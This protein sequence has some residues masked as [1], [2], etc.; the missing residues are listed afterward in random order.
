MKYDHK[1]IEKKWQE[2]WDVAQSFKASD[3]PRPDKKFYILD[4]FPYPSGD[5]LHVGHVEGYT[6]TDI[7]SRFKRMQSYDVLHPMGWDA[8]GLPAENYAIK[9]GVPP[10]QTTDKAID[11]FRRQIKELGLSY[12][13]SREVGAHTPEYYKW[14]QWFFLFLYNNGLAYKRMAKVNWCPKDQTVLANEQ[15]VSESG[16]KG[17]CVR[18]GTKVIQ[19]DL[20]QWFFKITDFAD[21]LVDDLDQVDWPESTKINQRNW[22]G[23][24]EGAEIEFAIAGSD[25][26]IKVFTTRP[27]TLFGATYMVLAPEHQ[28]VQDLKDRIENWSKIET[29]IEETKNKTDI[30]RASEGRE[31]TGVELKGVKAINPANKEEVSVYIA[32]YVM[33][34]YG[35]GAIMAVPAHD[36]RDAEFAAKFNIPVRRVVEPVTMQTVGSSAFKQNDPFVDSHGVI[37]FLKHWAEDK[38]MGLKWRDASD[39]GTLLTGGIDEGMTG[40]DTTRKEILEETGYKNIKSLRQ[41]TTIHSKYYHVPKKLNRFGHAP[42]FVVELADGERDTVSDEEQTKH[43]RLWLSV[44]ELKT[45]LTAESHQL[46]LSILQGNQYTGAGIL[47]D[48]GKFTGMQSEEAK[49]KITKSVDGSMVKTYRLRDW[50]ISR[51]R[52]WGAPI[53]VVYDPEGKAHPI[54]EEHLPWV[55]PTDVEFRPTGT[56][57]LGQSKELLDRTEKIFGKGWRPEIDT[58]DTFVCSS[59]YYFR[60][61]DPHNAQEFASKDALQ[62]WLPVDLYMGGAEHTVL[63]LLYARF[64][65][66]A[67]QKHGYV[68]FG[69]PFKKLRHQGIILA[70]DSTKMSKSKG[71]VIN[72]D[73]VIREYGADALRMYEMFMGPIEAMKPWSTKNIT[74][75]ARFLERVYR[76]QRADDVV[77]LPNNHVLAQTVK[78]VTEDIEALKLNTAISALM[79]LLNELETLP[80]APHAAYHTLITLLAPFAPHMA[81]ELA[82]KHGIDLSV[83]PTYDESKLVADSTTIAVQVNGKVRGTVELGVNASESD[84]LNAGRAVAGKWL[85]GKTEQKALYVPGKIINFVVV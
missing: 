49:Q 15:T 37:V 23:R 47:T 70:E 51:Q 52:Y 26:K 34:G 18:C 6:A 14:T 72:P 74:G 60:F 32:D 59:W 17:V 54:P 5:G 3:S 50:L 75:V 30:D 39:W 25:Q 44:D 68:S 10:Q 85:D 11:T 64:F 76:L 8:F 20:E 36:E 29:Y 43:E 78:K 65:T 9:T 21:A 28:L 2:R 80:Q 19:K 73:D 33:G 41:L 35:T 27:D 79:I 13:W 63:H 55:L 61:A 62:K 45:F 67:L 40:E 7:Y 81:S 66:K 84:A 24:S 12:D 77:E 82:E 57:P 69:E 16:E 53:P 71:N 31:K 48:S 83:W 38:Y 58:M 4:M 22:I 56:S 42:V 46:A 1:A